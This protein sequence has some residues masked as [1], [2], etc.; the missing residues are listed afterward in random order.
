[1]NELKRAI[2]KSIKFVKM[3]DDGDN[4]YAIIKFN[5]GG[6]L[7]ISSHSEG[8]GIAQ[9]NLSLSGENQTQETPEGLNVLKG[10]VIKSIEEKYDGE[11][12]VLEIKFTNG[13]VLVISTYSSDQEST[14]KIDVNIYESQQIKLVKES[15]NEEDFD[16]DEMRQDM[17]DPQEDPSGRNIVTGDDDFDPKNEQIYLLKRELDELVEKYVGEGTLTFQ[18]V[19]NIILDEL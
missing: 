3:N 7:N 18:E 12:S 10:K 17:F 14:A 11:D 5:E 13:D 9:L 1:M 8:K 6:K 16:E 15:L 4:S 2:G 19:R